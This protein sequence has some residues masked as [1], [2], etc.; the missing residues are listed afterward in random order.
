MKLK[1]KLK[2]KLLIFGITISL[3]TI[4]ISL[5]FSFNSNRKMSSMAAKET[6][7]LAYSDMGHIVENVDK[8]ASAQKLSG[9]GND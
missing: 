2:T 8:M 1:T 7:K 9:P 6:L 4:L 5:Y 3:I